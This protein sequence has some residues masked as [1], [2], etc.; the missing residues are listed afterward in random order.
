M[1][2]GC[3]GDRSLGNAIFLTISRFKTGAAALPLSGEV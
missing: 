1:L 3:H 2:T